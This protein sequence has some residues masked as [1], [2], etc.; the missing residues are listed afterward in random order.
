MSALLLLCLSARADVPLP[1]DEAPAAALPSVEEL[2]VMLVADGVP[3]EDADALAEDI[4]QMMALEASLQFESGV[5]VVADGR[6]SLT[7]PDGFGYLSPDDTEKVLVAWGNPPQGGGLGMIVPMDASLFS[8]EGWAVLLTY[9]EDGHITDD[10][11]EDMD[12]EELLVSMKEDI[13]TDNALRVEAGMDPIHLEGWVAPPHYDSARHRLYWATSLRGDDGGRSLNY[14]IRVLGREGVL[15]MSAIASVEQLEQ[16]QNDMEQ[17]ITFA[18][19]NSGHRYEQFDP[20]MDRVAAYGIGALVAG[21]VASK[22]G[23][24]AA[25]G[26]MLLKAKKLLLLAIIGI[27][28]AAKRAVGQRGDPVSR[29]P[30]ESSGP[31]ES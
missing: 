17:I 16:V 12:W 15:A 24:L 31:D 2:V 22:V 25:L 27:S 7:L 28:A 6:A 4:H 11:A 9:K 23:L 1:A 29:L 18:V 8:A 26:V 10:D 20:D 3:A 13:E 19:F 14:D 5:V 21:K 30:P